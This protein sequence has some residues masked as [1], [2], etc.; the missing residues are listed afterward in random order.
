VSAR[1]FWPPAEAAQADYEMLRTCVLEAG[2]LPAGLAAARFAR[3][4]LAGLIAWPVAEPVLHA[5][6]AGAARPVDPRRRPARAGAGGLLPVLAR[7]GRRA[8]RAG[9]PGSGGMIMKA[10]IYALLAPARRGRVLAGLAAPPPSPR[11]LVPPARPP[12]A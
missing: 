1:V 6:L 10:V 3:R 5:E 4:G 9:R 7:G 8:G 11:S 12:R 2:S